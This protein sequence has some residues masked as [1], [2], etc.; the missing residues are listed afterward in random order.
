MTREMYSDQALVAMIAEGDEAAFEALYN[1]HLECVRR[2]IV[3]MVRDADAAEDL[4][5]E[6]FLRIWTRS[7]QWSGAGSFRGWALRIA[8]NLALNHLRTVRRRRE[9]PFDPLPEPDRQ[10]EPASTPAWLID[11]SGYGPEQALEQLEWRER[12]QR[13]LQDLSAEKRVVFEMV[14]DADLGVG[15][16]ARRLGIPEGTARSRLY[17][18]RKQIVRR[19]QSELEEY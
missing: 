17:L 18:A 16:A 15:E 5:Q 8:V 10:S 9:L 13:L 19:W 6:V 11:R 1:R 2:R 14:H 7:E 3:T 4:S 12:L